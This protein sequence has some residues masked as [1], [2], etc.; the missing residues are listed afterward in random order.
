MLHVFVVFFS[1][2]LASLVSSNLLSVWLWVRA[3]SMLRALSR[4]PA[5]STLLGVT[6]RC[7]GP[8]RHLE[9]LGG[10]LCMAYCCLECQLVAMPRILECIDNI[11][12]YIY[13]ICE[14]FLDCT[15]PKPK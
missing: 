4:C 12:I 5:E 15:C 3:R 7:R 8:Y 6:E 11:R 2:L 10:C 13:N 1:V 9:V 14:I